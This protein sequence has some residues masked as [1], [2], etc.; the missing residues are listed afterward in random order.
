ML[1]EVFVLTFPPFYKDKMVRGSEFDRE[2]EH[3]YGVFMYSQGVPVAEKLPCFV[4]EKLWDSNEINRVVKVYSC[5]H[6][7][8]YCSGLLRVQNVQTT[9]QKHSQKTR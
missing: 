1:L 3:Y 9:P 4:Q 5:K 6:P 7:I 2:R 8:G